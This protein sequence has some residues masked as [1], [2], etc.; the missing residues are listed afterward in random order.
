M[1]RF[2][3]WDHEYLN[4]MD[5]ANFYGYLKAIEVIEAREMLANLTT[6]SYHALKQEEQEGI[7]KNLRA[8]AYPIANEKDIM[9][10]EDAFK[11]LMRS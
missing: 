4:N 10:T 11:H 5:V 1:A 6:S 8:K 2:Y 9:T 3:S 7:L